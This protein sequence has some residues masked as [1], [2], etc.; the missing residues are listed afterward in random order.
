MVAHFIPNS[1]LHF[2]DKGGFPFVLTRKLSYA[3]TT[4]CVPGVLGKLITVPAGFKTDLAS[5]PRVLWNVLPPIGA[6]D[7]AA[8][9]HDY[10]YQHNG[11][12]RREADAVLLEAMRILGVRVTQRWAIYAGVRAG[13]WFVW[14]RYRAKTLQGAGK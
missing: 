6:Y 10:L 9:V 7:A 3:T 13:G 5:I 12:S 8:V 11:V 4:L 2:T 1:E 14:N